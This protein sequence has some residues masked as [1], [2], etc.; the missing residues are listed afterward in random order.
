DGMLTTQALTEADTGAFPL[1]EPFPALD[2]AP[3]PGTDTHVEVARD[4]A[5]LAR[6]AAYMGNCIAGY[7]H[8]ARSGRCVLIA[9]VGPDGRPVANLDLHRAGSPGA[10]WRIS[11]LAA[12]FNADPDPVL[13]AAVRAWVRT[14]V[15]P[16][17]PAAETEPA[18]ESTTRPAQSQR[19]ARH[20]ER[21]LRDDCAGPL[22]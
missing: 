7:A 11:E 10:A 19:A 9:L 3:L 6:W 2:G 8:A 4:P 21:R 22:A 15:P 18:D 13:A 12:R 17:P 14:I 16:A 20:R 5:M 1:P